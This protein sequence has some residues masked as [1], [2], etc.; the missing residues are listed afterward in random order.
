MTTIGSGAAGEADGSGKAA[1][2]EQAGAPVRARWRLLP[3]VGVLLIAALSAASVAGYFD[4]TLKQRRQNVLLHEVRDARVL[5]QALTDAQAGMRSYVLTG[6]SVY[7]QA[8][9]TAVGA[10]YAAGAPAIR[11]M[12]AQ[13]AGGFSRDLQAE[14][15][16]WEEAIARVSAGSQMEAVAL[17]GAR[18]D[19]PAVEALR[20]TLDRS[21]DGRMAVWDSRRTAL[22]VEQN[23]LLMLNAAIGVVTVIVLLYALRRSRA[24]AALRDGALQHALQARAQAIAGREEVRQIFAMAEALQSAHGLADGGQIL[25]ASASQ[26]LPDLGGALYLF[27]PLRDRLDLL[28]AWDAADD[29]GQG[30]EPPAA[31]PGF[32]APNDCWALKRGKAH[33]NLPGSSALRCSHAPAFGASLELPLVG[34]TEP[35]GLLVLTARQADG[36]A[37]LERAGDVARALAD[38][39]SLALS[40]IILR[41]KLRHQAVRDSLTGLYNRRFLEEMLQSL[42]LQAQRRHS[43]LAAVMID[44]DHF[45]RL[46]DEHGH[47]MGDS[48]LKAVAA[49][50]LTALRGSDVAC[51]YGGEE[52]VVLLPDCT[53]EMA[54]GKAEQLRERVAGLSRADGPRV[55]A[56]FGVAA[57]P[58]TAKDC[59]TLLGSA[60]AALYVAKRE[61]RN[62]V[63]TAPPLPRAMLAGLAEP[64]RDWRSAI[65]PAALDLASPQG[66]RG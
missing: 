42:T 64:P 27:N 58:G 32:I 48:V 43:S 12:D 29:P 51:R 63:V 50:L 26:L 49:V 41:E 13:T 61:G 17:L 66:E 39:T 7:M 16:L 20:G 38:S 37:R 15:K 1:I 59:E 9:Y 34:R 5:A 44:L 18:G 45:K 57:F 6:R 56:S 54:R 21:M 14:T 65:T 35:V 36:A 47:A 60:D 19:K 28:I 55:T 2:G 8:Y 3:A 4:A 52:M 25:R 62:R 33:L 53:L 31:A 46:N 30:G 22:E 10:L 24:E 40:S 23:L 11:A